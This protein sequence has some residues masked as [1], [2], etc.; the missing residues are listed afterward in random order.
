MRNINAEIILDLV[1]K[2][3]L[4]SKIILKK[5]MNFK[6]AEKKNILEVNF[7][8][9]RHQLQNAPHISRPYVG[10]DKSDIDSDIANIGDECPRR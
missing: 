6:A 4:V 3:E 7:F 2:S 5:T 10:S 8:Y 1:F 9:F